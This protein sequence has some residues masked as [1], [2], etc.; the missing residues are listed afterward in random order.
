MTWVEL[1]YLGEF[2]KCF[3]AARF[4]EKERVRQA[5]AQLVA[6]GH[7]I[8]EDWTQNQSSSPFTA[9]LAYTTKSAQGDMAGVVDCELFI[10]LTGP[11]QSMGASAELGA[12]IALNLKFGVP[13]IYV[14]GEYIDKYFYAYHPVVK[15]VQS[16]EEVL[17]ELVVRS[18]P[19]SSLTI[20]QD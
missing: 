8:T 15:Q 13:Q 4:T 14:V 1:G 3:I 5:Q 7:S 19:Q 9:D 2:M 6:L 16:L 11:E 17:Q 12:A 10:L 18:L 20:A